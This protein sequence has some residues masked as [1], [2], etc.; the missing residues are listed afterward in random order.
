MDKILRKRV[1]KWTWLLAF[2]AAGLV[3]AGVVALNRPL[4]E[5]LVA[6]ENILPGEQVTLEMF[7]VRRLSLGELSPRYLSPSD[8]PQNFALVEMALKG[9]LV[10]TRNLSR[11]KS[12]NL[13]TIVVSPSLPVSQNVEPGSWVQVWRTVPSANGLISELIIARSQVVEISKSEQFIPE[14]SSLVELLLSREQAA[15]V[16]QTIASEL[17]LY[18][19]LDA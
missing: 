14:K 8:V 10:A 11:I 7:E 13:T 9:E 19:L 5:Y 15:V 3:I 4:P 18:V 17:N 1:S 2:G 6:K 12:E 16:L